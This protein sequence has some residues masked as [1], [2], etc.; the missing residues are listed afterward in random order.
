MTAYPPPP[1]ETASDETER[2]N[3]ANPGPNGKAN[4]NQPDFS[5]GLIF[6]G[7]PFDTARIF[8]DAKTY[9]RQRPDPAF[10]PRRLLFLVWRCLSGTFR[11]R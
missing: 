4:V 11:V 2:G 8:I 5:P 10:P 9:G 1:Y 3:K 6:A 7:S